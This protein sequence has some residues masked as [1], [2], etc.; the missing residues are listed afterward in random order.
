MLFGAFWCF[1][2]IFHGFYVKSKKKHKKAMSSTFFSAFCVHQKSRWPFKSIVTQ[3]STCNL[4]Y[5]T[6][7]SLEIW[8]KY[9][10]TPSSS[11]KI[12]AA[13]SLMT[14]AVE[15]VFAPMLDGSMDRSTILSPWTRYTLRWGSTTL[16]C[17]QGF[18]PQVQSYYSPIGETRI[19]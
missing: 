12:M 4:H 18:I 14:S 3:K 2:V 1:F 8:H 11:V 6:F 10:T 17:S 9:I 13:F 19:C 15:F 5:T 16:P 7:C